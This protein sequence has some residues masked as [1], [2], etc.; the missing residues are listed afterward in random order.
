MPCIVYLLLGASVNCASCSGTPKP[1]CVN[2]FWGVGVWFF[3]DSS[4][5]QVQILVGVVVFYSKVGVQNLKVDVQNP[6]VD[7]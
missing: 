7:V 1:N 4:S 5:A 6:K 2:M 3:H